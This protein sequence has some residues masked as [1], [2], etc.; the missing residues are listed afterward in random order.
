MASVNMKY[1]F[2][3]L[4]NATY[5]PVRKQ[6]DNHTSGHRHQMVYE[7]E[8]ERYQILN[9]YFKFVITRNPLERVLSG[10]RSK[11]EHHSITPDLTVKFDRPKIEMIK[12]HRPQLYSQWEKSGRTMKIFPTFNEY[13]RYLDS[14]NYYDLDSHLRPLQYIC[15]PCVFQYDFYANLKLMPEDLF[16]LLDRFDIP[17]DSF[18]NQ[19]APHDTESLMTKYYG[20]LSEAEKKMVYKFVHQEL[21]FYYHIYPEEKDMHI[22]LIGQF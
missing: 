8:G 2:A 12:T 19:P 15:H 10:Y 13:I 20:S 21:E 4:N 7:P 5:P 14:H 18:K 16:R 17:H 11:L 9:N 1:L 6:N 22:S 3:A